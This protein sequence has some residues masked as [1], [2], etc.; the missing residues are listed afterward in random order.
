VNTDHD[1]NR[2]HKHITT[3]TSAVGP[4]LGRYATRA[5]NET[6]TPSHNNEFFSAL[7]W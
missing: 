6:V 7:K 3:D 5:A 1:S 2:E 4:S